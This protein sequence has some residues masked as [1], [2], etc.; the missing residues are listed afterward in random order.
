MQVTWENET[1]FQNLGR[2]GF[3]KSRGLSV[4]RISTAGDVLLEPVNSRGEITTLRVVV[5]QAAVAEIIG[6]LAKAAQLTPAGQPDRELP[7]KLLRLALEL[8]ISQTQARRILKETLDG[9]EPERD[10]DQ[11]LLPDGTRCDWDER[12][13]TVGAL[14]VRT[15]GR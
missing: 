13:R 5:P 8:G 11:A 15:V 1:E 3:S 14:R 4:M 9:V 12:L 10:D 2:N 7:E 6:A